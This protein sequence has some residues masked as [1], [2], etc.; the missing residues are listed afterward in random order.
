MI[1]FFFLT[2]VWWRN[3]LYI[4]WCGGGGF[5]INKNVGMRRDFLTNMVIS[6]FYHI[7]IY[8]GL[9]K[10]KMF[11][12]W[13]FKFAKTSAFTLQIKIHGL[14]DKGR[15][16]IF[17]KTIFINFN[18]FFLCQILH[19]VTLINF[20]FT[21]FPSSTTS[22]ISKSTQSTSCGSFGKEKLFNG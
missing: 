3:K 22:K 11:A 13:H 7:L 10:K 4:Q 21:R 14:N 15:V 16:L 17:K 8:R 18:F 19:N 9:Q 12:F 2:K 1:F 6:W 5:W 20:Y